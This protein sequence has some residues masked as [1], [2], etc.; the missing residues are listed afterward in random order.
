MKRYI[1][2]KTPRRSSVS[3]SVGTTKDTRKLNQ[4]ELRGYN[5]ALRCMKENPQAMEIL[6]K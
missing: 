1:K 3:A 4:N 5:I 6:S 2:S